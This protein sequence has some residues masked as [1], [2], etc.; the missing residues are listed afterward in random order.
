FTWLLGHY[1]WLLCY[2]HLIATYT[3]TA[4]DRQSLWAHR[5]LNFGLPIVIF[6]AIA[7]L[8][9]T[10]GTWPLV[11]TYLYWQWFHFTRQ[12]Y[13]ASRAYVRRA[14]VALPDAK[15]T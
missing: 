8:A 3:R 11:T 14:A 15:L 6:G 9:G 4:F 1:L 7:L 10:V 5:F 12:S 2:P 13:G